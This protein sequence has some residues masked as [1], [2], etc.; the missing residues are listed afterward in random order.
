[1][2]RKRNPHIHGR[3]NK[4]DGDEAN[5]DDGSRSDW[6]GELSEMKGT[7]NELISVY[8]AQCNR[9]SCSLS[10][11]LQLVVCTMQDVP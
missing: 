3:Q 4:S 2:G 9:N 1:M 10:I 7:S 8:D 11:K 5:P 6:I